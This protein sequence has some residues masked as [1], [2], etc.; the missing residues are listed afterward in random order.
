MNMGRIIMI[1][2]MRRKDRELKNDE[3]VEIL[4]NLFIE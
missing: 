2:E 1:R 3:A 4:N